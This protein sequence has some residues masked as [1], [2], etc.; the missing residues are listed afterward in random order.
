MSINGGPKIE[1]GT[2]IQKIKA[3]EQADAL[4]KTLPELSTVTETA[5]LLRVTERQVYELVQK[6]E[7]KQELV[8]RVS[9]ITRES[10]A[11]IIENPRIILT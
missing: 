3:K 9:H 1:T 2:D 5:K 8:D 11:S 7:L 4:R 10:I 6:G